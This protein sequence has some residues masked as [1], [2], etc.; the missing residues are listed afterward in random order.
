MA[1]QSPKGNK[2]KKK[3]IV[4]VLTFTPHKG[5]YQRLKTF[6]FSLLCVY[7]YTHTHT[8]GRAQKIVDGSISLICSTHFSCSYTKQFLLHM[9]RLFFFLK[10]I[11]SFN[12][13]ICHFPDNAFKVNST[14]WPI[15]LLT[16]KL[17]RYLITGLIPSYKHSIERPS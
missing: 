1:L 9:F 15:H 7:L 5:K 17:K 13:I 12:W 11:T 14:S 6:M 4:S 2:K 8:I 3:S 10:F 16:Y